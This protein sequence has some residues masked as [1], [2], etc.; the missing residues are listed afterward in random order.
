MTTGISS[1]TISSENSPLEQWSLTC[2][3]PGT[4]FVEDNF[5]TDQAWGGGFGVIQVSYIYCALYF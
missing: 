4:N 2:L 3:T 1:L 5:S